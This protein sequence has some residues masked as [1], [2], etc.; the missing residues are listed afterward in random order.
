MNYV[1]VVSKVAEE[2][3]PGTGFM[4]GYVR[5][6]V[7]YFHWGHRYLVLGKS[8]KDIV[9]STEKTEQYVTGI[10]GNLTASTLG[11]G[12]LY[13]SGAKLALIGY[14]FTKCIENY[15]ALSSS[16]LE[17]KRALMGRHLIIPRDDFGKPLSKFS[18]Y[19][20]IRRIDPAL[21]LY[22]KIQ[23]HKVMFRAL[24][25]FHC[26]SQFFYRLLLFSGGIME[27]Y[28][29]NNA[30]GLEQAHISNSFFVNLK[31][32]FDQI[33]KN[34]EKIYE[35]IQVNAASIEGYLKAMHIKSDVK[36]LI[37]NVEKAANVC[38]VSS[39]AIR[40]VSSLVYNQF[41]NTFEGM[42]YAFWSS[43]IT[44]VQIDSKMKELDAEEMKKMPFNVQRSIFQGPSL[45]VI[46]KY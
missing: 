20:V 8:L 26:L 5:K 13:K 25:V 2:A 18:P 31:S 44:V 15:I 45:E 16:Y 38:S 4:P 46:A 23:A 37:K 12:E 28:M 11:L 3:Y 30:E 27:F 33:V 19:R 10:F 17:L 39:Q 6:G 41:M 9:Q 42:K 14:I 40:I 1:E 22:I 7:Y 34:Q 24:M 32:T 36:D 29:A 43:T 21:E 35:M